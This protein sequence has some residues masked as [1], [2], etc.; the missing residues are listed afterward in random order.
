MDLIKRGCKVFNPLN[1]FVQL[2]SPCRFSKGRFDRFYKIANTVWK[3]S[4][5]IIL[6]IL[7]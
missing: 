7:N 3:V 6:K 5:K 1:V 4:R 2:F